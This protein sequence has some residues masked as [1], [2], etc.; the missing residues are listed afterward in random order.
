MVSALAIAMAE[1][2]LEREVSEDDNRKIIDEC[3]KEW[4]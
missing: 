4:E 2:V 1:R 3:L